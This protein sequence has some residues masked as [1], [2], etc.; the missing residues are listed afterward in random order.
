[1]DDRVRYIANFL[2]MRTIVFVALS[3]FWR[4][5]SNFAP[6]PAGKK[7]RPLWLR[8]WLC[9]AFADVFIAVLIGTMLQLEFRPSRPTIK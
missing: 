7:T 1:M 6:P 8:S 2:D 3:E 9:V 5:P 4:T